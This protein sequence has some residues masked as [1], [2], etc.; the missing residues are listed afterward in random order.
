MVIFGLGFTCG[1]CCTLFMCSA[2]K[3]LAIGFFNIAFILGLTIAIAVMSPT[4]KVDLM[5]RA[6]KTLELG[7]AIAGCS[8]KYTEM[9][10]RTVVDDMDRAVSSANTIM[11]LS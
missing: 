4:Y 6:K 5:T 7:E 9:N 2:G 10:I 3:G 8:D 1:S 11:T